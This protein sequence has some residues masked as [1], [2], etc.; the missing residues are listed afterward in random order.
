[1]V[2][3]TESIVVIRSRR[4][5]LLGYLAISIVA[6][7]AVGVLLQSS[8]V[9]SS[10]VLGKMADATGLPIIAVVITAVATAIGVTLIK[11][12]WN[13]SI[14]LEKTAMR[15]RDNLG[16]YTVPYSNIDEVKA[17]ALG[18]VVLRLKD[19]EPWLQSASGNRGVR[20]AT[21]E[22]LQREYGGHVIFYDRHLSTGA[23][24]FVQLI[25]Q[26]IGRNPSAGA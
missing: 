3:R 16:E 13:R 8:G 9:L 24:R 17:V 14:V 18:G 25:E 22:L 15:V 2:E 21:A 5:R 26:R 7:I 4:P 20:E 12:N 19:P 10:S 11:D 1:M 6:G 23:A